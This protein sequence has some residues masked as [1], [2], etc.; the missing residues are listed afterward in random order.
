MMTITYTSVRFQRRAVAYNVVD[1]HTDWESDTFHDNLTILALVLENISN[2]RFNSFVTE[3]ADIDNSC[4]GNTL[5]N[6]T[7]R[8]TR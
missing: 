4:T 7:K 6:S 2:T 3:T 8:I 1:G 5:I